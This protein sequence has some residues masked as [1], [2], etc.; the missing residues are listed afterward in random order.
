MEFRLSA[1]VGRLQR[2]ARATG[3]IFREQ[4]LRP[5]LHIAARHREHQT[6]ILELLLHPAFI[7]RSLWR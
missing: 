2:T 5:S 4:R 7:K 6:L 1:E 3:R